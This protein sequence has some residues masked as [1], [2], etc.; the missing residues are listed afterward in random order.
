MPALAWRSQHLAQS[1]ASRIVRPVPIGDGP[2]HDRA[3][4][5]GQLAR[6]FGLGMPDR[7]QDSQH[8]R[9][10]D[11]VDPPA[12]EVR[13][14]V[15]SNLMPPLC[16]APR[17]LPAGT[18]HGDGPGRGVL[19]SRYRFRRLLLGQGIATETGQSAAGEGFVPRLG[20][21][22]QGIAAQTQGAGLAA[23][24]Q[25]AARKAGRR[26]DSRA[27]SSH[28]RRHGNPA[29]KPGPAIWTN[30]AVSRLVWCLPRGLVRMAF[31]FS[32]APHGGGRLRLRTTIMQTIYFWNKRDLD[33]VSWA[34]G[35]RTTVSI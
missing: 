34:V 13:K 16:L 6:R 29:W 8:V 19:E 33:G 30:W 10:G 20:Q 26:R 9:A 22:H 23:H 24:D 3:E 17:I 11:L 31:S 32:R 2:L 7:G 15:D 14:G 25:P 21:R 12:P 4:P 5:L 28:V 35:R 1:L 27:G 18:M